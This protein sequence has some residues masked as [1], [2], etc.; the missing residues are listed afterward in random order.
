MTRCR[1]AIGPHLALGVEGEHLLAELVAL[2]VGGGEGVEGGAVG[3]GA[4]P[5]EEILKAEE[6]VVWVA[7][8]RLLIIVFFNLDLNLKWY[9]QHNWRS[10]LPLD[11]VCCRKHLLGLLH[12]YTFRKSFKDLF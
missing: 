10:C 6:E 3:D 5:G 12:L 11:L 7:G 8:V 9:L 4:G 2:P 1:V